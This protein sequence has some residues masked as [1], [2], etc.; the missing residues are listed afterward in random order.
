MVS[1]DVTDFENARF[2]RDL[3]TVTAVRIY[4]MNLEE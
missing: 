1:F 2:N 4:L 3:V